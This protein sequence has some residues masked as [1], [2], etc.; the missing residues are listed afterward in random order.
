MNIL[1]TGGLGYIG[2]HTVV[3]LIKNRYKV[4]ILDN[5][6]NS[7]KKNLN[8]IEK[9]SNQHVNFFE[10]DIRDK[11][12]VNKIIK[13]KKISAIM[14]FAGLKSVRKSEIEKSEYYDVNVNGTQTLLDCFE[15]VKNGPKLF[16]FSSSACV[17]G[18]P[19]YLPYDENHIIEP[20]NYYGVTKFKAEQLLEKMFKKDKEWKI[21]ILRYFNPIGSHCSGLIG[22]D[23][24]GSAENLMPNILKA[25]D[26]KNKLKIFGSDH[27]TP[28][29][30]AVRDFIH[31]EDLVNGHVLT[32]N[33]LLKKNKSVYEIF[34][35]GTGQGLSVLE[36]IKTFE[37]INNVKISFEYVEKRQGDLPIYFSSAKKIKKKLNW[38][39][40]L[41]VGDMCK[42]S[43][44]FYKYN[45]EKI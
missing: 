18:D 21:G 16:V 36:L 4:T 42:S 19:L 37:R 24:K 14:H 30:T 17:Y 22:D 27:L 43:W 2:S 39:T 15:K 7:Y 25:I 26:N 41:S 34:D 20:Q 32:L 40:K 23:P 1:V 13:D 8:K 38:S 5:L 6:S 9:L 11:N 29:G 3:E 31:V 28:D 10:G 33:F 35:I 12:I 45:R 44:E